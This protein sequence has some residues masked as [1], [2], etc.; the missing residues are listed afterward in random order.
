MATR[1]GGPRSSWNLRVSHTDETIDNPDRPSAYTEDMLTLDGEYR[2]RLWGQTSYCYSDQTFSRQEGTDTSYDGVQRSL[3]L[4]NQSNLDTNQDDRLLSSLN[5]NDL[6]ESILESRTLTWREDLRHRVSRSVWDGASYQ[7]DRRE[8]Q[9][10]AYNLHNGEVYAEHQYRETIFS[11]LDFQGESSQGGGDDYTRYGPG[12]T[13]RYNGQLGN[14]AR[15]GVTLEGRLDQ[16]RRTFD[17]SQTSVIGE[18][19][20]LDDQRPAFLSL[21]NVQSSSILVSDSTG[22]RQYLE[23][24]DYRVVQRGSATEIQRV[25]GGAI[26]NGSTVRVDYLADGGTSQS[27]TRLY[28]RAAAELDLYDRL[29]FFYA[30]QRA[31]ESSDRSLIYEDYQ[32]TVAGIKNR[33]SWLEI[34]VEHVDHRSDTLGYRGVTSY[35][36]LFWERDATSARLHA[37]R[38]VLDYE[39]DQGR[40]DTQ[41]YT[42]TLN[43]TPYGRLSLQG[44]AGNYREQNPDGDRDLNTLETRILYRF[45]RL[46]LDATYRYEDETTMDTD[47]ERQYFLV[48]LVRDL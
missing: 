19:L 25:F 16:I 48:R 46:S 8:S 26:P 9:D 31:S 20:V 2:S 5:Y 35:A 30:D 7:Y 44:F 43:W 27:L 6:D 45:S 38:S 40:L 36:D 14:A 33:W 4:I 37:G 13:E 34:G 18:T 12:V 1:G 47:Y 10:T 21:P 3:Y 23:G 22:A 24:Y 28:R 39:D 32:D 11:R 41:T 15:V 29:L 42:F 17:S